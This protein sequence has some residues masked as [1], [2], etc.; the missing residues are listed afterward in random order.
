MIRLLI[1]L[2]TKPIFYTKNK[3]KAQKSNFQWKENK[4]NYS[5]SLLG[6]IN[7][8]IIIFDTVLV[9]EDNNKIHFRKKWW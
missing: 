6:I 7:G 8:I 9:V 2:L 3:D 4:D 1:Y 5:L